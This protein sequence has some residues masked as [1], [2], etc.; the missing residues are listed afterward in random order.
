MNLVTECNQNVI[1]VIV[2]VSEETY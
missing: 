1:S 2:K